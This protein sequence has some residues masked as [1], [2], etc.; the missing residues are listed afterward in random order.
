[1]DDGLPEIT[2]NVEISGHHTTIQRPPSVTTAFRIFHVKQSG[3]LTLESLT[4]RGGEAPP[5]PIE[6][7]NGGG[8]YNEHGGLTLSNVTVRNNFAHWLGGGIWNQLGTLVMNDTTVTNNST[9]VAA[10]GVATNGTMNMWGGAI[11]DNT[12]SAWAGGLANGGDTKLN[13][14][15]V[16]GNVVGE[17]RPVGGVGGGIMTLN[18]DNHTGPLRLNSTEVRDNISQ[19]VGGGIF[20]G[21]HQPTTL[22]QSTVTRNAANGGP[23]SGGGIHNDGR[24]F[25]IYTTPLPGP[26]QTIGAAPAQQPLPKVDLIESTVFK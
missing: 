16:D 23:G 15:S 9:R 5:T 1:M 22:Y 26:E 25:G 24:L 8:I 2:G 18:I 7:S 3:S 21:A 17:T 12:S 10:G 11:S 14:V 19:T 6:K 13:H 20:I 4:V